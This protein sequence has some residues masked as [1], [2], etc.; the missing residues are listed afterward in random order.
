MSSGMNGMN[1]RNTFTKRLK[2]K[3]NQKEILELE[4][5]INEMKNAL[6]STGIRVD[7]M[8]ERNSKLEDKN[9]EMIQ[10]EEERGLR[11]FFK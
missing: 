10:V 8:E 5:S 1:R 6:E 4:S 7:Q 11:F 9:V 2:L 3:K